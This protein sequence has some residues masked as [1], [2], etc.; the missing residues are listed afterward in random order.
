MTKA[1]KKLFGV[2]AKIADLKKIEEELEEEVKAE[3]DAKKKEILDRHHISVDELKR[4]I[5]EKESEDKKILS[6]VKLH[7]SKDAVSI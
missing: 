1:E 4:M 7:A 6:E 3:Q 2:R 5:K